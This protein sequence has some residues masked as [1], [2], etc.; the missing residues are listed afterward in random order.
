MKILNTA[1][2]RVLDISNFN[3]K[4]NYFKVRKGL[5]HKKIFEYKNKSIQK[6]YLENELMNIKQNFDIERF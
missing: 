5:T 2:R 1:K 6:I 4:S 3:D